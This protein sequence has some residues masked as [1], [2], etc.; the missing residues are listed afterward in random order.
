MKIKLKVHRNDKQVVEKTYVEAVN[1]VYSVLN[2]FYI[3]PEVSLVDITRKV[4]NSLGFDEGGVG[5]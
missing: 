4:V 1:S 5:D 3:V 2:R